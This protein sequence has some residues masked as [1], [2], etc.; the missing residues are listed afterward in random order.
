[1][2]SCVSSDTLTRGKYQRV[3]QI[4]GNPKNCQTLNVVEHWV[5]YP[6]GLAPIKLPQTQ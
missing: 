6:I 3:P 2:L 1:M 4:L 5:T